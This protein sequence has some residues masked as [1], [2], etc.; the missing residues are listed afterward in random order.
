LNNNNQSFYKEGRRD[1]ISS[2][3]D[4]GRIQKE[5][6]ELQENKKNVSLQHCYIPRPASESSS[7]THQVR[8]DASLLLQI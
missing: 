2:S 8:I 1:T 3:M 4:N 7:D 5:L 6:K